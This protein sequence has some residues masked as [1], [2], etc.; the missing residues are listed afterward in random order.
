MEVGVGWGSDGSPYP[1]PL[2]GSK[3]HGGLGLRLS[4]R[5]LGVSGQVERNKE[6]KGE[7]GS[8]REPWLRRAGELCS[9]S[10]KDH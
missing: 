2:Q 5:S 8:A 3:V 10:N 9:F 6:R 4:L 7:M 1:P